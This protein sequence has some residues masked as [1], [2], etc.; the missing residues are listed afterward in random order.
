MTYNRSNWYWVISSVEWGKQLISNTAVE[1]PN[2][3]NKKCRKKCSLI[4]ITL[5]YIWKVHDNTV[6]KIFSCCLSEV[7]KRGWTFL[8][9]FSF[10]IHKWNLTIANHENFAENF[11]HHTTYRF[12]NL[13]LLIL[14][15]VMTSIT[16]S[17]KK[18][19]LQ[20][21]IH[22]YGLLIS[23]KML[24]LPYE[25]TQRYHIVRLVAVTKKA[26]DLSHF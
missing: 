9:H 3:S 2:V 11:I 15:E 12:C 22:P 24:I 13:L 7:K 18:P 1:L 5:N 14:S 16:A 8:L 4:R 17:T 20:K 23:K 19:I 10:Q 21:K 6:A 25:Y 26:G